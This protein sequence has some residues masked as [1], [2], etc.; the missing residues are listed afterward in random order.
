MKDRF[1]ALT[2]WLPIEQ[3]PLAID[4]GGG[5]PPAPDPIEAGPLAGGFLRDLVVNQVAKFVTAKINEIKAA[6]LAGDLK[7]MESAVRWIKEQVEKA[8]GY[9]LRSEDLMGVVELVLAVTGGKVA[10][11]LREL[12]DAC[13]LA[14]KHFET[15]SPLVGAGASG[16]DVVLVAAFDEY[17][18][19]WRVVGTAGPVPDAN[20]GL[21]E[22]VTLGRLLWEIGAWIRRKRQDRLGP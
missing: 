16:S 5:S 20:I 14:A 21:I 1:Q 6:F 17:D 8:T 11:I 2:A 18:R 15:E 13:H 12:G 10:P 4:G 9:A 3:V 7:A 22:L 19:V